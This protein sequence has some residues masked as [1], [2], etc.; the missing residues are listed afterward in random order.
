MIIGTGLCHDPVLK[1]LLDTW[2]KSKVPAAVAPG[3]DAVLMLALVPGATAGG[4]FGLDRW[5]VFW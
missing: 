4:T 3:T 1:A 2:S 5:P